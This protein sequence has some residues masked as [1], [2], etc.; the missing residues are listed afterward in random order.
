[1]RHGHSQAN[2]LGIITCDPAVCLH[3]YGLT[4]KGRS[5]TADA[6]KRLK[7]S[8]KQAPII[9]SS[10]F[11]RASQT[12]EI[13]AAE[14]ATSMILDDRL[15]ER[16]F[17]A[18]HGQADSNYAQVWDITDKD[19]AA[20][21]GGVESDRKILARLVAVIN[22]QEMAHKDQVVILV[23]HGDPLVILD[24]YYKYGDTTRQVHLFANA[25]IR[26]LA[27]SK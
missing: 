11:L 19:P 20:E 26:P 12:A 4:D 1:M 14:F 18:L 5:Q 23:S 2:K 8:V 24:A 3:E 7:Q 25:E 10:D 6:V 27:I 17:G 16:D 9:V 15:R 13:V 21:P 22:E